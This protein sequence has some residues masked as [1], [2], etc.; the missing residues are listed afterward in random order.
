MTTTKTAREY[1]RVSRDESGRLR[2]PEEQHG[3]NERA[4]EA[5]GWA[6]GAPYVEDGAVSASR[7]GRKARPGYAAL[8]DDL[9]ADRVGAST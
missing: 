4:A 3:D 2:S 8:V 5:H 9:E 6:L 7:Y 1:L